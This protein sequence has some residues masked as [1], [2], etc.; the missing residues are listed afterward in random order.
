MSFFSLSNADIDFEME[1]FIWSLF[2]T[3]EALPTTSQV[4]LIDKHK[5][6]K[7]VLDENSET[8]VVYIAELEVTGMTIHLFKAN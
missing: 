4:P 1:E 7:A 8:F 3:A 6:A 5:F 2:I